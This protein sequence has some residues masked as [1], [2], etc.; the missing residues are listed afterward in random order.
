[1][2]EEKYYLVCELNFNV[3]LVYMYWF[4]NI[5]DAEQTLLDDYEW[6]KVI[7][8]PELDELLKR[9]I[10]I[11]VPVKAHKKPDKVF[12]FDLLD[13][14][15]TKAIPAK[16]LEKAEKKIQEI[17]NGEYEWIATRTKVRL[18]T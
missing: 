13:D 15:D 9:Y 1:M 10:P 8:Q 5:Y 14:Y 12:V 16:D 11:I 18:G 17:C 7:E 3:L 2:E 4:D 6:F